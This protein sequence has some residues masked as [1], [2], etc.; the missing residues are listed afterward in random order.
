MAR[1][2]DTHDGRSHSSGKEIEVMNTQEIEAK[3]NEFTPDD[4]RLA[5]D[6]IQEHPLRGPETSE[7]GTTGSIDAATAKPGVRIVAML[8][9]VYFRITEVGGGCAS[10][11]ELD[12]SP[13]SFEG[14]T[15]ALFSRLG[16]AA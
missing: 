9:R 13:A 12:M 6:R 11:T 15:A 3:L 1:A 7:R 4:V 14:L 2:S 16:V 8:G 10:F 5:L